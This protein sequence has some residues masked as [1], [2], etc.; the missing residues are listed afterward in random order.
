MHDGR[1]GTLEEVIGH[2]SRLGAEAQTHRRRPDL[3]LPQRPLSTSERAELIAFLTSL[4]DESFVQRFAARSS[5]PALTE[6]SA[7]TQPEPAT[8]R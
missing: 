7:A 6:R 4:T 5:G 3:R 2:Y 8:E 1:F